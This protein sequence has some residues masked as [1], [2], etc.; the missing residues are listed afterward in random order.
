MEP[1]TVLKE[2]IT[3][4]PAVSYALGVLGIIS[5]IAIVRIFRIDYRVA[6]YGTVIMFVLMVALLVFAALT[7]VNSPQV[8]V[9]ALVMMWSFLALII[10]SAALLFLS[11]FFNYPKPLTNIFGLPDATVGRKEFDRL[12]DQ[13]W[14]ALGGAP[15]THVITGYSAPNIEEARRALRDARYLRPRDADL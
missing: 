7:K 12:L 11:A 9:A 5:A 14:D 10:L 15:N 1:W 2:A 4:V 8:R 6:V 13:A 3:A